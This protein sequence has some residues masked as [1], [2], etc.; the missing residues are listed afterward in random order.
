MHEHRRSKTREYEIGPTWKVLAVQ[1]KTEPQ[2]VR[3][4]PYYHLRDRIP[5]LDTRHHLTAPRRVHYAPDT[6]AVAVA[7]LLPPPV[8]VAV[9]ADV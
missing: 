6:A 9:G 7:P 3:S 4:T 1:P 2:S 5:A 8:S